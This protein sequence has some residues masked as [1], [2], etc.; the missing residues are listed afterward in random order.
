M[1]AA[2]P[3]HGADR[4][5]ASFT[6]GRRALHPDVA[7]DVFAAAVSL[8]TDNL[9]VPSDDEW[10]SKLLLRTL[11]AQDYGRTASNSRSDS[12]NVA[13][14]GAEPV[15]AE[16][17]DRFAKTFAPCGFRREA[18]RPCYGLAEA[19]L[20]VSARE[21]SN[22]QQT[23]PLVKEVSKKALEQN[24]IV[25]ATNEEFETRKAV[26]CG[27]ALTEVAI[28]NPDSLNRCAPGEV[29][30]IWVSGPNVAAGYWNKPVE[31][32]ETFRAVLKN[33]DG[34]FL[35]TG[36]LGFVR[37]G[38]LFLTGRLKD[39]ILSRGR[40]HY[41]QDIELTVEQC[42]PSL[43]SGC[44]AAF[45]VLVHDE[46]RVVVVQEIEPR[47]SPE[48]QPLI[49]SIRE[50]I[51][52]EHE[53]AAHAIVLVKAGTVPKT[54]SGKI[55]RRAC[56]KLFIE[57]GLEIVGQWRESLSE[58]SGDQSPH[59]KE[60]AGTV[61]DWLRAEFAA[62]LKMNVAEV[63][64]QQPIL[65]YGLD[66]LSATE[67]THRI[68]SVFGVGVPL[69]ALLENPSIAQLT[70]TI[71]KCVQKPAALAPAEESEEHPLSFGQKSL[72]F[73]HRLQPESA[74]YNLS[75]AFRMY[76]ELDVAALQRAFEGLVQ[77]HAALRT[78]FSQNGGEPVQKVNK[79]L[80][81]CF[82]QVDASSWTEEVAGE[83]LA[84]DAHRPFDLSTGP[85]LR[86][87]LLRRSDREHVLLFVVHHIVSDFWSLAVLM[88]ELGVL[89][90]AELRQTGA[91]LS[92]L[93]LQY[94]D[95]VRQET[96]M[97]QGPRGEQLW[98]YW[99]AQLNGELPSLNLPTDRP[100]PAQQSFRGSS[101]PFRLNSELALKLRDLSRSEGATLYMVLLAAFQALLYRYTEQKEFVVGSPAAARNSAAMSSVS[102]YFVNPLA[103][104]ADL[105][106]NPS[107]VELL[108]RVRRTVLD[109]FSHQE[110]PFAL[111]VARLQPTRDP[112]RSPLFQHMFVMQQSGGTGDLAAFVLG[113]SKTQL[114]FGKL[115]LEPVNL[116]GG[117]SLFDLR[118]SVAEAAETLV[119]SMEYNS[120]LFE[121]ATIDRMLGHFEELLESLVTD[122]H[123]S[124]HRHSLL[125]TSERELL[126]A[127]NDTAIDYGPY[128]TLHELIDE[129][130]ERTPNNVAVRFE[131]EEL[132]YAEL[133]RRADLL[134]RELRESGVGLDVTVGVCMERS[135]ELVVALLGILKAGGAYVPLDPGYPRE[136]LRF[137]L[138]DSRP[139]V[140]LTQSRLRGLL[141]ES[142]AAEVICVDE[143]LPRQGAKAQRKQGRSQSGK[144]LAYVI[145]T[146][147]STGQPKGAMNTHEGIVNRLL[148]MQDQYRLTAADC[149]LQK[150][151]FS[152]DVSVWEFFWPLIT[153]A[154]LVLARPGGHQDAAYLADLIEC[155]R[156]TTLH[157]VPSMLHAF[158]ANA[159]PNRCAS[160]KRVIC[161]GEALSYELQERFYATM[162]AELHNLYGPT[163]AAVD[164]TYWACQRGQRQV[165][166]IGRP[167][168]NTE[169]YIV[170]SMGQPVPVGVA[171]ELLI[172]GVGLGRG[173]L[174]RPDL[175]AERFQPNPFA[176]E[177][178]ARL[179]R[180]GDLARYLADGE[181]EYL[182]RLDQQVKLRGFRIELGEIEAALS[183]HDGVRE[184]VVTTNELAPGDVRLIA[185]VVHQVGGTVASEELRRHLQERLPEYMVPAFF[186][187][188]DE[189]PRLPNGKIDR[190]SLPAPSA[191]RPELEREFVPPRNRIEAEVASIWTAVLGLEQVGV[192]DNFFALGGHSL[193]ATQI[194]SRINQSFGIDFPLRKMFDVP[195]VAALAEVIDQS[196]P[197]VRPHAI[198]RVSREESLPLSFAQQRLWFLE[199][200][201]PAN[202][203]YNM[204]VL[205]RIDGPLDLAVLERSIAEI[206]RRHDVL[207]TSIGNIAG[208]PVQ[209]V[210]PPEPWTLP[211]VDLSGLPKHYGWAEAMR[212]ATKEAQRSFDLTTGSLLRAL[213]LRLD[214]TDHL[215]LFTMH[216]IVSDGWS[217]GVFC[218]ELSALYKAFKAGR[219][220]PLPELPIQY[221][222]FVQWQREHLAT[223]VDEQLAY[224]KQ[225]LAG[226]LPVIAL[227][228]E[229]QRLPAPTVRVA[230]ESVALPPQ[231]HKTLKE[232]S[233]TR[234][235]TLFNTLLTAFQI[236]L[237]RYTGLEDIVV[238]TPVAGRTR[239]ETETLIGLF[240][241]TL[242]LR[243]DL[244]GNPTFGELLDKVREMTLEAHAHQDVPF[245]MLVEE[246]HPERDLTRTPLFQVMIVL[247]APLS[248]IDLPELQ[249]QQIEL[250][251]T[252][253]KF[254]LLL[255]LRDRGDELVAAWEYNTARLDGGTVSRMAQQFMTLLEHALANPEQ[256][257]SDL[258]LLTEAEQRHLLVECNAT[259]LNY[260]RDVC[261]HQLFETQVARTPDLTALVSGAERLSYHDLNERANR[262]AHHL[263]SLGVGPESLVGVLLERSSRLIVSLLGVLKAG[264]AYVPLDPAY[265]RE[266]LRLMLDDAG[267]AVLLTQQSLIDDLPSHD[268]RVVCVDSDWENI[269][270]QSSDNLLNQTLPANLAYVIYTSGSTGKPKGAAIAHR[271][272]VTLM[273][274][275]HDFFSGGE[276]EGVLASTSV[277]FD[278]SVFEIFV[279]L[280]CGG[281][282]ILAG[283]A[284]EL[285]TL[286][287]ANE[288]TL[289]NTVP[290]AMAELIRLGGVP[291]SVRVV[292]LAG[293]PLLKVLA[294]RIY[295]LDHVERLL[296][297]YGP[298][299]DTTYSTWA[300]IEKGELQPPTIG[301]P[302][303]DTQVYLLDTQLH[304]VPPG[305]TGELYISGEG[306]VRGYLNRPSLT[307]EKF[308]PNPFSAEPG[309]RMYRTGDLAR[310]LSDGRIDFLGRMDHQVK[311]RGFRI[312]LGEIETLLVEHP[313][314]Q[315]AVVVAR[316]N[317]N[318]VAYFVT[319]PE[320]T[321]TQKDLR[322]YLLERLPKHMVPAF[323]VSLAELPLTPNGK[324]NRAALPAPEASDDEAQG[325][326]TLPRTR[327]EAAVASLWEQLLNRRQ[328]G[329]H[330][331]FFMLG[332]HS[333]LAAQVVARLREQFRAELPLRSIFERPTVAGLAEV[334]ENASA[335]SSPLVPVSRGATSPVS[336]AQQRLWFLD[337]LAPGNSAYNIVGG[338]RLRGELDRQAFVEALDAITARH[339]ILRTSFTTTDGRPVQV[340][341]PE[342]PVA[343]T[344]S[345]LSSL[346]EDAREGKVR[347]LARNEL[348][349]PFDLTRAP[350]WRVGLLRLGEGKHV[351]LVTMHHI[352]ADGW[353]MGV[354]VKEFVTLYEAI[355]NMQPVRLTALP[356]QYADFAHW[357]REWLR[358]ELIDEQL[359]YWRRT[360][361]GA[362][363]ALELPS[364][365]S[366]EAEPALR[367]EKAFF[368][369][370]A[371]LSESLRELSRREGVTLFMTLLAAFKTLL[372]RY[373]SQDDVVI[374][375]AIAGR[376][377]VEV[378][379]L[380]GIFINM[381]VLRT[382]LAGN[383]T[384]RELLGR[385]REVTLNAYAHQDVPFERLVEK[386]QPARTSARSPFFQIAFGLQNQ[387]VQ[388]FSLPGLELSP[389]NF[390]T[391]VSR[392]DLTLWVFESEPELTA[393]WTFNTDL[394]K[395]ET[396]KLM[397]M[398]FETLLS[399]IVRDPEACLA[400][401]EILSDEEK[402]QEAMREQSSIGK[403]LSVK[404][405]TITR[406]AGA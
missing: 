392:Y 2:L 386:L 135:P 291:D 154:R 189:I 183:T 158:L 18:F 31:S 267:V 174:A 254:D 179:Y 83:W 176:G 193:L 230:T 57:S 35:R 121:A 137:M 209:V 111:L 370:P 7:N 34:H 188:L 97:L 205:L 44:G 293:E 388:S 195:T 376:S 38:E 286:E 45:S 70:N 387:P 21:H 162:S 213:V 280:T 221:A 349:Q 1:V 249:V 30:E 347:A 308:V 380:I 84:Q 222:D 282:V 261:L 319:A 51:S 311:L 163:E 181:I 296:N 264:A 382:S 76:G 80:P 328:V 134:A 390:D 220:S 147:G 227:P 27:N 122:P 294:Q 54:S 110:F 334:I 331:D 235:T 153:G 191:A 371:E 377:R 379:N 178:G 375:T 288:V 373:T 148:W 118:L 64:V 211:V 65:R 33:E 192:H 216:H 310:Y 395:A 231:L 238:G 85:L 117:V 226:R 47:H 151:P 248:E 340:V 217:M 263:R 312:E 318:L 336:F 132:T 272:V 262:V 233:R 389:L 130:A 295:E 170:D 126:T 320:Q 324:I 93:S 397:H 346:D 303:A 378:E 405:R 244:S 190:R 198:Q 39:V 101:R 63:D 218:A 108:A 160:L 329:I 299:E 339:E 215:L 24:R 105:S 17:I 325:I 14:N 28:V 399:H 94:I 133:E 199:Q 144:N 129:Q 401:L 304:P 289:I 360:L 96:A 223:D 341:A 46:E 259:S 292:N 313:A 36:D 245:E 74:A 243:S 180:S 364:D 335:L 6:F 186:V 42:H 229:L 37:D 404:R 23:P 43:R 89:Y 79:H 123:Q 184:C 305:V 71:E 345:D 342:Y 8:V 150:T 246:L 321:V 258:E 283:N 194:V 185:Y 359:E 91:K 306:L 175:T 290:S 277:C 125:T 78:T 271:S 10:W 187:C 73:L 403:L 362:P 225:Q 343:L 240:A 128:R 204:P 15:R 372:Y 99:R 333:L 196:A 12:W 367:A 107:F 361:A 268:A 203:A 149:V 156:V 269:A 276:L 394:F 363:P 287:T 4:H 59:S 212:R 114:E 278:L 353:S 337:Q 315:D 400:S 391:D 50:A 348:D 358:D 307:A 131:D 219:P 266:R 250:A 383:P 120:D 56:R 22:R 116:D 165:V 141:P 232:F 239:V 58:E 112:S 102:G 177:P 16:T 365:Q 251:T 13:F 55:Q 202:A 297:L 393:S 374:G 161:S 242:V 171:G 236:L 145:Y 40:N 300:R 41:P 210:A 88:K 201:D 140:L 352:I 338:M 197:A 52:E 142:I 106:G 332:G 61:E 234:G 344:F 81:V 356:I 32:D 302:L 350:L 402:Q 351:V 200:L 143:S 60:V 323:F 368:K 164:V 260:S 355:R 82:E 146:S 228:N 115:R 72:W 169:I 136:R 11:R 103:L 369:I 317:E 26:G 95:Y 86:V 139:P 270:A 309:A 100:R 241:N 301:R 48:L 167:I 298:S 62:L 357:Q 138:E 285:P 157:F 385:V 53:I 247:D 281:K 127:C 381:L 3:R 9:R 29:G 322:S 316:Q 166:P 92:P 214:A 279:P 172:G 274:W 206:V 252:A 384:F 314:V 182:G 155:E 20:L 87:S 67:L 406:T 257:I 275:S 159:S 253:P 326:V 208:S 237:Q 255:F 19:T 66:S 119:G 113:D 75:T 284:L 265:P 224:W 90:E 327:V 256:R 98:N 109:A 396:I 152:F 49:A 273:H 25:E 173:Y 330:D 68:E 5:S 69:T 168:A 104:R 366:R 207:R 124:L 398:R 354:F 77:R